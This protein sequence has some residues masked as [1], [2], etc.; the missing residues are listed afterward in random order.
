LWS[1]NIN[2][3]TIGYSYWPVKSERVSSAGLPYEV[4]RTINQCT[5]YSRSVSD[6]HSL[7]LPVNSR[8]SRA[9]W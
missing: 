4:Y 1:E 7:Y 3:R 5:L 2:I 8:T 9:D 6:Y